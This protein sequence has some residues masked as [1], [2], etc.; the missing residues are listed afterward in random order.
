MTGNMILRHQYEVPYETENWSSRHFVVERDDPGKAEHI[1]H[2]AGVGNRFETEVGGGGA[3]LPDL[4]MLLHHQSPSKTAGARQD[5]G[6]QQ[7]GTGRSS[8]LGTGN[9]ASRDH[10]WNVRHVVG[11]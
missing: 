7:V 5:M 8:Q 2:I 6:R 10:V 1:V 9:Y 4:G 3:V 11:M